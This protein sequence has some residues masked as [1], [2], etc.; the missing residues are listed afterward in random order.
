MRYGPE[1]S[2]L[3]SRMHG[4]KRLLIGNHD[5]LK[6]TNLVQLFQKVSMWRVFGEY[7]F[8]CSHVPLHPDS[9]RRSVLNVHGHVHQNTLQDDRYMNVSVEV[10]DYTPVPLDKVLNRVA[11]LKS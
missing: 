3:L 2:A 7:G 8:I 9:M 11:K 1:L 6:G 10:V 4:K 5:I